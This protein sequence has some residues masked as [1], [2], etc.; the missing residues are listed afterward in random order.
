LKV[1]MA[2]LASGANNGRHEH[3]NSMPHSSTDRASMNEQQS[4]AGRGSSIV[5]QSR[6]DRLTTLQS[7]IPDLDFGT[8]TSPNMEAMNCMYGSSSNHETYLCEVQPPKMVH[9]ILKS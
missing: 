1:P 2:S 3:K 9:I 5:Q 6:A 7:P 4:G 8:T